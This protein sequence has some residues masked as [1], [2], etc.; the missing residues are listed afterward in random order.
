[1]MLHNMNSEKDKTL[2]FFKRNFDYD[3]TDFQDKVMAQKNQSD[4]EC[5]PEEYCFENELGNEINIAVQD[6][7]D[8]S[9][10]KTFDAVEIYISGPQSE[11]SNTITYYEAT[12]LNKALTEFLDSSDKSESKVSIASKSK[13]RKLTDKPSSEKTLKDWFDRKGPEGS[14]GGWVDCNTCRNGKCKPCGRQKGEKRKKYPACRPTPASCK[15]HSKTKGESWGK[16]GKKKSARYL[17]I[18]SLFIKCSEIKK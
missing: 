6:V 13:K 1:M 2:G 12:M 11:T 18:E 5:S 3:G 9:G 16:G 7:E 8:V 15:T 4:D 14:T 10:N 17:E